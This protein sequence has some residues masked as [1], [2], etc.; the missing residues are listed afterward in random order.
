[1]ITWVTHNGDIHECLSKTVVAICM[2]SKLFQAGTAKKFIFTAV[3]EI[4]IE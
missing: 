3:S 2:K 4:R 1:M